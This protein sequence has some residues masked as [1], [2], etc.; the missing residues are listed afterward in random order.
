[1]QFQLKWLMVAVAIV[2]ILLSLPPEAFELVGFFG[3]I[4]VVMI[5]VPAGIAPSGRR[6]EAASWSLALHPLLL[7]VWLWVWRLTAFRQP[8]YPK[9]HSL[10]HSVILE[11]PYI[12]AGLSLFY[13]PIFI[14]LGWASA[15][16]GVPR[17]FVPRSPLMLLPITWL[18]TLAVLAW[19]P[20]EL[21][22]WV[23]D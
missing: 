6:I 22:V 21:L 14:V 15:A 13:L 23:R 17:R 10:H 16:L 7:L 19:D 20:F 3:T 8:L 9:D 5:L 4:L 1:M 18:T 2:A 11:T 12:M